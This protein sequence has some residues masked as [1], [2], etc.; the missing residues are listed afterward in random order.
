[1][2]TIYAPDTMT[3]TSTHI[4]ATSETVVPLPGSSILMSLIIA[5]LSPMFLG[6]SAGDVSLARLAATETVNAYRARNH[7]DLIAIAQIIAFGLAAL[8]S[9]SL[10]MADDISLPMTLRLRGNANACNRSAE[11][12][13]RA[14]NH[15]R[16]R[17]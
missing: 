13:R 1:M 15:T 6:V 17:D 8:G 12:N 9:L 2:S 16:A 5:L 14:L 3:E 10:A 7:A 11:Q 4:A